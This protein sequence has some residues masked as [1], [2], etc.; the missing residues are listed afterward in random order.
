MKKGKSPGPDGLTKDVYLTFCKYLGKEMTEIVNN[1]LI[2][3]KA[4]ESWK[5]AK[6]ILV[7]KEGNNSELKN[8]RPISR[9][10][11]DYKILAKIVNANLKEEIKH[12]LE[13]TQKG[14][15]PDRKID[16]V[17]IMTIDSKKAFDRVDQESMFKTM[18]SLKSIKAYKAY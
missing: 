12:T 16:D 18:E 6:V 15:V 2:L 8:Y 7:Y 14:G 4:P 9:L 3:T 11:I 10:L 13:K 5:N 17:H 1:A